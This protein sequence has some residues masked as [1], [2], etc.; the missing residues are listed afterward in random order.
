MSFNTCLYTLSSADRLYLYQT[1]IMFKNLRITR[2][3]TYKENITWRLRLAYHLSLG[4]V[5][6]C[7]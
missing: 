5:W 1:Y 7:K 6:V 3:Y 2:I 4:Y